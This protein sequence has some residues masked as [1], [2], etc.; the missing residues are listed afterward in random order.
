MTSH[1]VTFNRS[2]LTLES[3][4]AAA[5]NA[6]VH[7][8]VKPGGNYTLTRWNNDET[9]NDIV[10]LREGLSRDALVA[11]VESPM[12]YN[13][14]SYSLWYERTEFTLGM[15]RR[16]EKLDLSLVFLSDVIKNQDPL[17]IVAVMLGFSSAFGAEAAMLCD[18]S[19]ETAMWLRRK[20]DEDLADI[21]I[22]RCIGRDLLPAP[23]LAMLHK[24]R[25]DLPVMIRE[26][27][28]GVTVKRALSGYV[29]CSML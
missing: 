21:V 10:A 17:W 7:T 6:L 11:I 4:L 13:D 18:E 25:C 16:G 20:A 12:S 27:A 15:R 1:S 2:S 14:L 5:Q 29:V 3:A 22:A 28:P 9:E 26:A 8:G 19:D 24:D 23:P